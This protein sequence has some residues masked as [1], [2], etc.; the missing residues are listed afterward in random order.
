[1]IIAQV[2][3]FQLPPPL[4]PLPCTHKSEDLQ[5]QKGHSSMV[6]S[7]FERGSCVPCFL[8]TLFLSSSGAR[9]RWKSGVSPPSGPIQTSAWQQPGPFRRD[10]TQA[11]SVRYR[12]K[13]F[14]CSIGYSCCTLR[15]SSGGYGRGCWRSGWDTSALVLVEVGFDV[16]SHSGFSELACPSKN[17]LLTQ[18]APPFRHITSAGKGK[19]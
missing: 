7:R 12:H 1:M 17:R 2:S 14:L 10:K 9:A 15:L 8:S 19:P 11:C 13:W 5:V 16:P 18:G 4:A 6:L 3:L